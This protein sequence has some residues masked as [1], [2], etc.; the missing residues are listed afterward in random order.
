MV[1]PIFKPF[2]QP[3]NIII[4]HDSFELITLNEI[5]LVELNPLLN[6]SD[7]YK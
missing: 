5:N 6:F 7:L 2:P 3:P 1:N 4:L